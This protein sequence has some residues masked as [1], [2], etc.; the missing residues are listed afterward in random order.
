VFLVPAHQE[1]Q[2]P[3]TSTAERG[4]Q[5]RSVASASNNCRTALAKVTLCAG[6][7]PPLP[8]SWP[9]HLFFHPLYHANPYAVCKKTLLRTS[10]AAIMAYD[11]KGECLRGSTPAA[12]AASSACCLGTAATTWQGS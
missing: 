5:T 3:L 4:A 7:H 1:H 9:L 10:A 2:L 6:M 12:A 8:P 11:M